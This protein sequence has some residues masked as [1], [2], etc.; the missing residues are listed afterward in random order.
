MAPEITIEEC[1]LQIAGI[2]ELKCIHIWA[3]VMT[4][5][6]L[7]NPEQRYPFEKDINLLKANTGNVLV[8]NA[9]HF[10]KKFMKENRLSMSSTK[11]M[12]QQACYYQRLGH[13]FQQN[14]QCYSSTKK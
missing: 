2:E 1:M 9:E 5:F 10:L 3:A 7:L 12:A 4:L 13:I 6:V 14:I 8:P 11:Y